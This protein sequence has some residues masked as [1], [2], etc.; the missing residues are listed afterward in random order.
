MQA[1]QLQQPSGE[2]RLR[3]W[4]GIC[5]RQGPQ[6]VGQARSQ[7]SGLLSTG[8]RT[9]HPLWETPSGPGSLC[10]THSSQQSWLVPVD[11]RPPLPQ[12]HRWIETHGSIWASTLAFSGSP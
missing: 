4:W 3:M 7:A 2:S 6:S 12:S 1:P 9:S 8:A 11:P 5:S 10:L